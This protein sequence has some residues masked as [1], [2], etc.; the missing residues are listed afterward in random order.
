MSLHVTFYNYEHIDF[1]F[2]CEEAQTVQRVFKNNRK[3]KCKGKK[4]LCL[5]SVR[6]DFEFVNGTYFMF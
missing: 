6:K 5:S 3:E 2:P 1:C 4:N